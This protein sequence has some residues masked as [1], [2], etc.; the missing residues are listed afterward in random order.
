MSKHIS[1]QFQEVPKR[2]KKRKPHLTGESTDAA[3]AGVKGEIDPN[4]LSIYS[5][6][7][8]MFVVYS[9]LIHIRK[10]FKLFD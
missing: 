10:N 4:I 8:Y 7:P 6:I 2:D 5:V 9:L 1:P 3:G